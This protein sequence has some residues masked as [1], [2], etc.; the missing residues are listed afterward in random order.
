MLAKIVRE[1]FHNALSINSKNIKFADIHRIPQHPVQTNAKKIQRPTIIKLT[2]LFDKQLIYKSLKNLKLY[3][4]KWNLKPRF[5]GYIF[6]T[7]H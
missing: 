3:N 4:N 7:D 5:P 2:N 1:F 6:L